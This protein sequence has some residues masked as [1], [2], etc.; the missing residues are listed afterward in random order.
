M[1]AREGDEEGQM[2]FYGTQHAHDIKHAQRFSVHTSDLI[3]QTIGKSIFPLCGVWCAIWVDEG[4]SH[5]RSLRN[6]SASHTQAS[7]FH[8]LPHIKVCCYM[9]PSIPY[10]ILGISRADHRLLLDRRPFLLLD[11]W[12]HLLLLLLGQRPVLRLDRQA[13]FLL[14]LRH[15]Y[16][17]AERLQCGWCIAARQIDYTSSQ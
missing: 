11:P 17:I 12:P 3:L 16:R 9:Y 8:T 10:T 13:L 5:V 4:V 15:N 2:A 1:G 14:D 7:A 6:V